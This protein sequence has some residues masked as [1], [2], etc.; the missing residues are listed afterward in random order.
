MGVLFSG[1]F[2]QTIITEKVIYSISDVIQFPDRVLTRHTVSGEALERD[3]FAWDIEFVDD[4]LY[5]VRED[6]ELVEA[7]RFR[8]FWESSLEIWDTFKEAETRYYDSSLPY[9]WYRTP[10]AIYDA[11]HQEVTLVNG[12]WVLK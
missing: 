10:F 3:G 6:V 4:K 12:E 1:G 11:A 8:W 9:T 2:T 7:T 5:E